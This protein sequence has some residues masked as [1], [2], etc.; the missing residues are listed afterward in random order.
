M[1]F[2]VLKTLEQSVN[3]WLFTDEIIISVIIEII[4]YIYLSITADITEN[5][6]SL[7]DHKDL[8]SKFV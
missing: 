3:Q 8:F 1:L 7:E 6:G 4:L 2:T 5:S